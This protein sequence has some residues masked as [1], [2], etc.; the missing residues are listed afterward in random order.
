MLTLKSALKAIF[1]TMKELSES[2]IRMVNEKLED[3]FGNFLTGIVVLST[4]EILPQKRRGR[5]PK[6]WYEEQDRLQKEKQE[7][8]ARGEVVST[9]ED[10]DDDDVS[11]EDE[12]FP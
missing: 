12:F 8:K 4:E 5:K 7:R 6:T 9:D 10:I 3:I 2:D 11:N 1:P